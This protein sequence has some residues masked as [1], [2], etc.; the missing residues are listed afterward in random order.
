MIHVLEKKTKILNIPK[1]NLL[2]IFM[3]VILIYDYHA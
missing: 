3:N 2:I 1:F